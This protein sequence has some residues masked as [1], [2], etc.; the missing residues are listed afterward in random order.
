MPNSFEEHFAEG[1]AAGKNGLSLEA[2]PYVLELDRGPGWPAPSIAYFDWHL[3]WK[4]ARFERV[5][6]TRKEMK[7]PI[8]SAIT[9]LLQYQ[10]DY[11]S[12]SI[13]EA[14]GL[15]RTGLR[16]FKARK[17]AIRIAALLRESKE[18]R[19][20]NELCYGLHLPWH[21]SEHPYTFQFTDQIL[22]IFGGMP[23]GD[24]SQIRGLLTKFGDRHGVRDVWRLYLSKDDDVDLSQLLHVPG[25]RRHG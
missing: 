20:L 4:F 10:A 18:M 2:C 1:V 19:L 3:G 13:T 14:R 7:E 6:R 21:P 5:L 22:M 9:S 25:K 24:E 12:H 8:R 23:P 11:S 16:Y 15:F 17:E